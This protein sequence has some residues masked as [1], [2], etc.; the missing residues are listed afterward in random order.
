MTIF[1]FFILFVFYYRKIPKKFLAVGIT[2]GK[3]VR[4]QEF[5]LQEGQGLKD[6]LA[7]AGITPA[8][9]TPELEPT[10]PAKTSIPLGSI[11]IPSFR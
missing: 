11:P 10:P 8:T 2:R 4:T 6:A 5:A 3:V 1:I 7:S 9:T